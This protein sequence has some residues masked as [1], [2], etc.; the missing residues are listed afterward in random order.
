M[1]IRTLALLC[2]SP[3]VLASL[4]CPAAGRR[5]VAPPLAGM[6]APPPPVSPRFGVSNR[7]GVYAGLWRL[8]WVI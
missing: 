7:R 4:R 2:A 5:A 6:S 8:I 3:L 1:A